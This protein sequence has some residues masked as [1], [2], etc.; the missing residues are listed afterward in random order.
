MPNDTDSR[1]A[2]AASDASA[3]YTI[4]LRDFTATVSLAGRTDHTT[5]RI[6][7]EL[8]VS[9]PGRGFPDDIAA[10]M[11]YEDIVEDLRRLCAED[12]V[13]GPDYL[14]DR[15]AALCLAHAKV[16]RVRVDVELSSAL[17]DVTGS[18]VSITRE[19]AT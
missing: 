19:Q 8:K 9:H 13:P 4:L 12:A 10:V 3:T 11:S 15:A 17:P 14:A 2:G 18:G 5:A 16:R 7:L 6:N 1:R